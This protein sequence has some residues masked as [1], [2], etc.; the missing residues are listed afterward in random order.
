ML[1][2]F[3][4]TLSQKLIKLIDNKKNKNSMPSSQPRPPPRP[5]M[6]MMM[7]PC[8]IAVVMEQ[9]LHENQAV[10]NLIVVLDSYRM[11]LTDAFKQ[12]R[13]REK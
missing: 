10:Q 7:S 2:K 9:L 11:T 8:H 13:K 3:I 12:A 5:G 1:K 6:M 4:K